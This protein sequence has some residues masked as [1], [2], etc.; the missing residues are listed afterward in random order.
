[1]VRPW[2]C[3]RGLGK[4]CFASESVTSSSHG[5]RTVCSD[6][7]GAAHGSTHPLQHCI[8]S[9]CCTPE[10]DGAQQA[11]EEDAGMPA[12][13]SAEHRLERPRHPDR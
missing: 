8:A 9:A 3:K 11:A 7:R 12:S 6:E 2:P 1:M 13:R 4:P 10:A 5:V